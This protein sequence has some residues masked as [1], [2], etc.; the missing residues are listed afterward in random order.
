[1]SDDQLEHL[2]RT[3]HQVKLFILKRNTLQGSETWDVEYSLDIPSKC[4]YSDLN[5][6]VSS[7]L[8][9]YDSTLYDDE[10][11]H[12]VIGSV[13]ECFHIDPASNND[14]NKL[15]SL[16]GSIFHQIQLHLSQLDCSPKW[17]IAENKRFVDDARMSND[18]P[19]YASLGNNNDIVFVSNF[20]LKYKRTDLSLLG[21]IV[22]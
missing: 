8:H 6:I 12:L 14:K 15:K 20:R 13:Y 18:F 4:L 5:I 21:K 9:L 7:H 10:T 3:Y 1:M 11:L 22:L 17:S 16:F 2:E 19:K